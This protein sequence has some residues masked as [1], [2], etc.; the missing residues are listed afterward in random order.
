MKLQR[1][2]S[3]SFSW[4]RW[5]NCDIFERFHFGCR[6]YDI[7]RRRHLLQEYAVGY[8]DDLYCRRKKGCL[9]VMFLIDDS[10]S[11]CHLTEEEFEK[12][13]GNAR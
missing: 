4:S 5:R 9:G 7:L 1:L 12:V 3:D 11:W 2:P 6:T 8:N 10:F 13:F